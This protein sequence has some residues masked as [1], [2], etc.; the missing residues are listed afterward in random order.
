[1]SGDVTPFYG[2]L[3][4]HEVVVEGARV[5]LAASLDE[6][7][8]VARALSRV[9]RAALEV[10]VYAAYDALPYTSFRAGNEVR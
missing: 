6:A 3:W 7:R 9:T 10:R 2:T 1:V 4:T 8:I 5:A